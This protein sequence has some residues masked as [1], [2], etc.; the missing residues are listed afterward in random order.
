[1]KSITLKS[2]KE[3][4]L[5][6]AYQGDCLDFMRDL[7]DKCIDLVLTDPPYR[8]EKENSPARGM[9]KFGDM[10]DFGCKLTVE[11]YNEIL[12][13]SKHQIIW[14]ANNFHYSFKGFIE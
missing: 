11:Q 3:C 9:V 5:N 1:M 13:I 8:E 6:T 2:G 10:Q 4:P 7:P 14:G 12:R